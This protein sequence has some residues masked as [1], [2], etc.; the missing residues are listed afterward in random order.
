MSNARMSS[1]SVTQ[2]LLRKQSARE[3]KQRSQQP[4]T[5]IPDAEPDEA[6]ERPQIKQ[7]GEGINPTADPGHRLGMAW[8]EREERGGQQRE[9]RLAGRDRPGNGQHQEGVQQGAG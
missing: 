5:T 7:R 1:G 4:P 8:H 2:R 3:D 9:R 6:Q